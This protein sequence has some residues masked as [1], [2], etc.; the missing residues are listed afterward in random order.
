MQVF[1]ANGEIVWARSTKT[2]GDGDIDES[3][4]IHTYEHEKTYTYVL[5]FT[6]VLVTGVY[7][8]IGVT[9]CLKGRWRV[10]DVGWRS[11]VGVV[12]RPYPPLLF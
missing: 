12:D 3:T 9:V 1:Y 4:G 10:G 6:H 11:R 5:W 8:Y 2:K 7:I